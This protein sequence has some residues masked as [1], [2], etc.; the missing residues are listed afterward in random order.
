MH[1]LRWA[2]SGHQMRRSQGSG[3]GSGQTSAAGR[4]DCPA[5]RSGACVNA[6]GTAREL[7]IEVDDG[8][9]LQ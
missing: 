7:S 8:S 4:S 2:C 3:E 1:R 6:L 9:P 5:A